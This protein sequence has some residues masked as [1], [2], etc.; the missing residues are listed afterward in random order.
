MF[1]RNYAVVLTSS[2]RIE[3]VPLRYVSR[4]EAVAFT[5]AYNRH[6]GERF[7][8][9]VRHPIQRALAVTNSEPK[10]RAVPKATGVNRLAK[11]G[12]N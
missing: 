10:P 7:A 8:L 6:P 2:G 3:S 4:R 11:I 1:S 5:R 9:V 12:R